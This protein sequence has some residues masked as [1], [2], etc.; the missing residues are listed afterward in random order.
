MREPVIECRNLTHYY[1]DRLIYKNLSFEIPRGR[2][3]GLLGKNGTGKTTTINILNGYLQPRS[4]ECLIFGEDIRRMRPETRARIALLIEGHVQYAFM[5]IEQIERFYARFYPNWDRDAYYGLME[6]LQVAPRQRISR[7]SCGQR[8][9]VALGLILA[10]NAELLILDDFSMGLDPGYRRLFVEYLRDYARSEEKTVFL[11]SHIIQD[12]EKLVDDCII[13]DYGRIL[14]Q[15][16]VRDL[17]GR[18]RR[19]TFTTADGAIIPE[20]KE[21]YNPGVINGRG[22]LYSFDSPESIRGWLDRTGIPHGDLWSETL[23]LEDAFI[24]LTGKY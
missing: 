8:S 17:L 16:P 10:Q 23:N 14:I 15:I 22:E 7:M 19:Y 18:F 1:G 6:K 3:L 20:S 13:M 24:G 12:M 9:Q 4:G 21:I 2:I 5:T 11:T